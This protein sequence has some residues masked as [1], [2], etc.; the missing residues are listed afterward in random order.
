MDPQSITITITITITV[1]VVVLPGIAALVWFGRKRKWC[2]CKKK[3]KTE[4][5]NESEM[6]TTT[7][8]M[9]KTKIGKKIGKEVLKEIVDDDG[10]IIDCI[11][12]E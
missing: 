12:G 4:P 7:E 8:K 2:D 10:A 9:N 11:E 6:T 1:T 3:K 5:I